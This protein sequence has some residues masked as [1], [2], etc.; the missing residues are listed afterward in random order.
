MDWFRAKRISAGFET[1]PDLQVACG[2]SVRTI[3]NVETG[4]RLSITRPNQKALAKAL[5]VDWEE[6]KERLN[7]EIKKQGGKASSNGKKRPDGY[8]IVATTDRPP[9]VFNLGI[10][11]SGW[12]EI[13]KNGI[14]ANQL[15]GWIFVRID[16]DSMEPRAMSGQYV[17]FGA[18]NLIEDS[19]VPGHDYF[20]I[21]SDGYGTFKRLE[22]IDGEQYI[23]K[24]INPKYKDPLTVSVQELV[25]V[26]EAKLIANDLPEI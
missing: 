19:P 17:M 5:N 18:L 8:S 10:A 25:L 14:S 2:V 20:F 7:Y 6:F 11:A 4:R 12:V 21:R 9:A 26:A 23:L 13:G 15:R 22:R 16:G 1:Q 3:S 24:A